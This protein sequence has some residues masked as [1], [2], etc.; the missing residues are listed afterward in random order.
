M[1]HAYAFAVIIAVDV[2]NTNLR[3]GIVRTGDVS[4]ARG[5]ATR[6]NRS[7]DRLSVTL[8]ELLK[9]DGAAL[10][11]VDAIVLASVV[12]AVSA[13]F[14]ELAAQ[15]GI[16]LVVA[17]DTTIPIPVRVNEPAAVGD[18]RLVN[19]FAA[20][21]LYGR[22]AIVVDL[23]TATTLDVVGPD[24]A[25][26]GGAIAPG[27]GLGLEALA[28]RTAQLPRVP[29]EVPDKAIGTDT[30]SAIQ[31]GAVL[32]YFGL[33]KELVRRIAAE[34]GT[35]PTVILTGGLSAL[36]WAR[37]I[38]GVAAIDPLLTLRGLAL[39]YREVLALPRWPRGRRRM[40][41]LHAT[42][43]PARSCSASRARSRPIR[44]PS[45]PAP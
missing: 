2:G 20:G 44:A 7:A 9:E 37:E 25:F 26:L 6:V 5:A 8:D 23:G 22:P 40:S 42:Q 34:L 24:G 31:S 13:A 3:V 15:R 17:D 16:R 30:L 28:E 38:P 12:P 21:A 18:D 19:A 27:L 45:C 14:A 32:G 1:T 41:A 43:G 33:V 11:D 35:K 10:T 4:G 29:L 39:V 36:P